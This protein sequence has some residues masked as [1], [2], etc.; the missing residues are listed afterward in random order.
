MDHEYLEA[1]LALFFQAGF[2][3]LLTEALSRI[4]ASAR[5]CN[6][7]WSACL[8]ALAYLPAATLLWPHLRLLPNQ[9]QIVLLSGTAV[10]ISGR[11]LAVTWL[12]GALLL[13]TRLIV[14]LARVA[15]L[16][17]A[18]SPV[19]RRL[20][21]QV[22][23]QLS[24]RPDETANPLRIG[25]RE[26]QLLVS[27]TLGGPLCG[28]LQSPFIMLPASF[29]TL[30]IDELS[31]VVR[32]EIEHLRAG[33]P[34][35]LF[36]QKLVEIVFWPHP[37]AWWASHQAERAREFLC[38]AATVSSRESAACYLRT[39]L[40]VLGGGQKLCN[41]GGA[42]LGFSARRRILIDRAQRLAEGGWQSSTAVDRW[43]PAVAPLL[44]GAVVALVLWVPVTATA[45]QRSLWSPWPAA[46]AR[47]LKA[48]S[49]TVRDYEVD[50]HRLRPQELRHVQSRGD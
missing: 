11:W 49:I 19:G 13:V 47:C 4:A 16:R 5:N 17:R 6:R 24:R 42:A 30:A 26:V 48:V 18:A 10:A 45:S 1:A 15:R 35:L 9:S 12:V 27:E 20:V 29:L 21:E 39:L 34:L 31:L 43:W 32:H 38:D 41:P 40:R 36:I 14:D 23:A 3:V 22:A 25:G 44:A 7:L 8:L 37:A 28:Q 46:A 33:H 2:V 50:G